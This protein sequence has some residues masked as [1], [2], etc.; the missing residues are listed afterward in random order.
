M[1]V[2]NNIDGNI[3]CAVCNHKIS[4]VGL[5]DGRGKTMETSKVAAESVIVTGSHYSADGK[6]IEVEVVITCPECNSKMKA[7][8]AVRVVK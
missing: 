2:T 1:S 8:N 6:R 7:L 3:S 4:Y 5:L